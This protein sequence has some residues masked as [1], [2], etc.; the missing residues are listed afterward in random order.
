[1]RYRI[2]LLLLWVTGVAHAQPTPPVAAADTFNAPADTTLTVDAPGV[3]AND[4]DADGDVLAAV[5]VVGPS[6][7]ALT[8][9]RDGSF[10]YTPNAGF[11][12]ADRFTYLAEEATPSSFVVDP[13]QSG[14]LFK[15]NL[16]TS[17]GSDE[18]QD[19]SAV[20]G[21]VAA[22]VAPNIAPFSEIH[23]TA[24]N[25]TLTD[26]LS[27]SFRFGILG[28]LDADVDPDSMQLLLA[29]P[30]APAAVT[31]SLFA[32]PGNE[33]GIAGTLNLDASGALT[34][35]I[36]DGPQ[37]LDVLTQGDLNGTLA[38]RDTT[39]HLAMP[40]ALA[41]TFDVGGNT[42]DVTVEGFVAGDAAILPPPQQ[43]NVATVTLMVGGMATGT[44]VAKV[45][46][47]FILEQN[48]PNPFNPTTTIAYALPV[49]S[50][51]SLIVYD[52]L[53]RAIATL[54]DTRQ[55]AGR[56]EAAFDASRLPSGM[57]VYRLQAG[58]FSATKR[59]VVLR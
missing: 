18:D 19:S 34:V 46:T 53:G 26:G 27:I 12:G 1:M 28:R 44:E 42:V 43:S 39:L 16:D 54:V 47:R 20:A 25:L 33:I 31:D 23:L 51:V 5:L 48:Y 24:M 7:G 55:L 59:L 35:A 49:A 40:L 17:I 4:S 30:G 13:T 38:Q 36:S 3:L 6:N 37:A 29:R 11:T 45:P 41:G 21:L 15:A 58:S 9:N 8:L 32:Q 10:S 22:R 2:L 57:Y 56:H 52:V 50:E 14:V